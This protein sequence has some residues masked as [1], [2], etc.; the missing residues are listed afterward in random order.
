MLLCHSPW[1]MQHSIVQPLADTTQ[2][3]SGWK[4]SHWR[5]QSSEDVAYS[6]HPRLCMTLLIFCWNGKC[7]GMPPQTRPPK[8]PLPPGS[9]QSPWPHL[10]AFPDL[11]CDLWVL[12]YGFQ[13][14]SDAVV[15]QSQSSYIKILYIPTNIY[16]E[17][18]REKICH[19]SNYICSWQI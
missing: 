4:S 8:S 9:F 10:V 15:G 1:A 5:S 11:I 7:M 19:S 17:R 18:E 3:L 13:V 2:V 16:I 14:C 12:A 6:T